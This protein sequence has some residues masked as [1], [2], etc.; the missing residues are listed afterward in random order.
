MSE[1]VL[2]AASPVAFDRDKVVDALRLGDFLR[3]KLAWS[4]ALLVYRY[5]LHW[6][7]NPDPGS[8]FERAT[9]YVRRLPG[10]VIIFL[11][12]WKNYN[13]LLMQDEKGRVLGHIF[14]QYHADGVHIFSVAINERNRGKGLSTAMLRLFL[15]EIWFD[16]PVR[17]VRMGAGGHPALKHLWTKAVRGELNLPFHVLAQEGEG[18]AKL[19]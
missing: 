10:P 17:N 6:F 13:G 8:K 14:C 19:A 12:W 1:Q 11:L 16:T 7:R 9:R 4:S 3:G 18:W 5:V 15:E 2:A